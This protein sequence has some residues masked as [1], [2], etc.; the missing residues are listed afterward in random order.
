MYPQYKVIKVVSAYDAELL[1]QQG[2]VLLEVLKAQEIGT[3]YR[4]EADPSATT[5]SSSLPRRLAVPFVVEALVFLMGKDEES[6]IAELRA[7]KECTEREQQE[8]RKTLEKVRIDLASAEE[9]L[10][11]AVSK[12]QWHEDATRRAEGTVESHAATIRKMETDLAKIRAHVG[13]K[14]YNEAISM[15]KVAGG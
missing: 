8:A 15:T 14:T 5:Y 10:R 2:W 11:V 1:S 7:A 4:E 9:R 13:Q 3:G 6:V 12:E